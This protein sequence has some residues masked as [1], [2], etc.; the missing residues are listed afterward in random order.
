M[1]GQSWLGSGLGIELGL[2]V[3]LGLGQSWLGLSVISADLWQS[4]VDLR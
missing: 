1:L 2:G 3:G 4:V